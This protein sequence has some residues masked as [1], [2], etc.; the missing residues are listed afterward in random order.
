M[1][2]RRRLGC[3]DRRQEARRQ[4]VEAPEDANAH[5]ASRPSGARREL[6]ELLGYD[7]EERRELVAPSPE[8]LPGESPERHL[9]DPELG[10]PVEKLVDLV[11]TAPVTLVDAGEARL[12]REAPVPVEDDRNVLG[13]TGTPH[14]AAQAIRVDP[15]ERRQEKP[16]DTLCHSAQTTPA[17]SETRFS[18]SISRAMTRRWI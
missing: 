9:G 16:A 14:L 15:V 1:S 2:R 12:R 17:S 8:V 6:V 7:V 11:R 18:R 13:H 4:G 10:T 3:L 5:P